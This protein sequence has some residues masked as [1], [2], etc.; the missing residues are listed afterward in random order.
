MSFT[1][2][3]AEKKKKKKAFSDELIFAF[4]FLYLPFVVFPRLMLLNT[5]L[6]C[7]WDKTCTPLPLTCCLTGAAGYPNM[8][9]ALELKSDKMLLA[10]VTV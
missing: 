8:C 5:V 4:A 7:L 9:A 6:S 10:E 2:S 3:D 1:V